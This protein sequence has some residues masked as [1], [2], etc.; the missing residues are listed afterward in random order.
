MIYPVYVY[1]MPVLRKRAREIDEDYENLDQL[2]LDMFETMYY[3]D[4]VGLAAPQ[5]GLSIRLLVID[6][7]AIED[8]SDPTLKDFK[9]VFINPEIIEET[10]EEWITSEG[11]LSIPNIREDVSRRPMIRV[12][13]YNEHF[14]FMDE[15]YDGV[16]ARIIQHETDHLNGVLFTD[17]VSPMRKRLL[18]AKLKAISKGDADVQYKIIFPG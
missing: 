8:E 4:G 5:I 1:G 3:S 13:Y 17:R 12:Q 15:R 11:C 16:K 10:G 6:A 9:K 18:K 2:I 14:E 7:S